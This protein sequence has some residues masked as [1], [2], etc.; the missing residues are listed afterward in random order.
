MSATLF[1]SRK[2]NG[3]IR[4]QALR[5]VPGARFSRWP[6]DFARHKYTDYAPCL[7][8][9]K[10]ESLFLR[11]KMAMKKISSANPLIFQGIFAF[12]GAD[13]YSSILQM[14]NGYFPMLNRFELPREQKKPQKS[15]PKTKNSIRHIKSSDR[16]IFGFFYFK[17]QEEGKW[18]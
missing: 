17:K 6:K 10:S 8:K 11:H 18:I 1:I 2:R 5:N 13:F 4:T 3:G 15:Y 9:F 7:A 16:N 12:L 14:K